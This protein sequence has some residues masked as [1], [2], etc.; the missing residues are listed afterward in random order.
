MAVINAT[1][2]KHVFAL[3]KAAEQIVFE[4]VGRVVAI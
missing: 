4:I 1:N 3:T 2:V